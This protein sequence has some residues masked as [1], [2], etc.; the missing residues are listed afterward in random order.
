V[1][2]FQYILIKIWHSCHHKVQ[3]RRQC[4][5]CLY[6]KG[7]GRGRKKSV[8]LTLG[9]HFQTMRGGQVVRFYS[10]SSCCVKH[11]SESTVS[12]ELN[13][14]EHLNLTHLYPGFMHS[15]QNIKDRNCDSR[16]GTYF[17]P[18]QKTAQEAQS[19]HFDHHKMI[20]R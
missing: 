17:L 1:L 4:E 7:R 5:W 13:Q 8:V 19:F 12:W 11:A 10:K 2:T 15:W 14:Y 18:P 20:D 3:D 16:G 6:G 9:R